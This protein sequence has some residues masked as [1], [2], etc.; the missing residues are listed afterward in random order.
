MATLVA[1]W[2][3]VTSSRLYG[4]AV[5]LGA[6]LI[7][8]WLAMRGQRRAGRNE[9]ER[10]IQ[11]DTYEHIIERFGERDEIRSNRDGD[12]RERLRRNGSDRA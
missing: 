11:G 1:L 3:R 2:A 10:Q 4:Y 12:A 7:G 8:L 9:A 5:A 6:V